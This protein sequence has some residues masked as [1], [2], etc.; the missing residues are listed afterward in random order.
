MEPKEA[1]EEMGKTC[2]FDAEQLSA[3]LD[4]ALAEAGRGAVADH[5]RACAVCRERVE[6]FRK[7]DAEVLDLPVPGWTEAYAPKFTAGVMARVAASAAPSVTIST[8]RRAPIRR[9]A[10]PI[11]WLTATLSAA[12]ALLLFVGGGVHPG[13]PERTASVSSVP[14]DSFHRESAFQNPQPTAGKGA[15]IVQGKGAAPVPGKGGPIDGLSAVRPQ[16]AEGNNVQILVEQQIEKGLFD[17]GNCIN[18]EEILRN[19]GKAVALNDTLAKGCS[20]RA[21]QSLN[22]RGVDSTNPALPVDASAL[23]DRSLA[24]S[25]A[26]MTYLV[27]C[28]NLDADGLKDLRETIVSNGIDDRVRTAL[29]LAPDADHARPLEKVQVFLLRLANGES[30]AGPAELAELKQVIVGE[31]VIEE[32]RLGRNRT[33]LVSRLPNDNPAQNDRPAGQQQQDPVRA[34]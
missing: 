29:T 22:Y 28:S 23:A 17:N 5:L 10:I 13:L 33:Q 12:A 15:G 8:P 30:H 25:E 14:A 7:L 19:I 2:R 21:H 31:G 9:A 20:W 6:G 34:K 24:A 11:G 3:W 4:G 18:R 27:N 1:N 16:T 32:V 26:V